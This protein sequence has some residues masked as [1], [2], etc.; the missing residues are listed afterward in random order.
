MIK[1]LYCYSVTVFSFSKYLSGFLSEYF[2][3]SG[4]VDVSFTFV[5]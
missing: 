5:L 4:I 2:Q 1:P 3:D